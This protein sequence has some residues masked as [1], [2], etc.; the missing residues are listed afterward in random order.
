MLSLMPLNPTPGRALALILLLGCGSFVQAQVATAVPI[1]SWSLQNGR[2]ELRIGTEQERRYRIESSTNLVSW[3]TEMVTDPA[4]ETAAAVS[5]AAPLSDAWF[6]KVSTFE[7]EDLKAGLRTARERWEEQRLATYS[8]EFRW[9]CHCVFVDWVRVSVQ[10]GR[11]DEITSVATGTRL[12]EDQ[13]VGY[14]TVAG[15]FD[16]FDQQLAQRPV[17]IRAALDPV[18]GYPVSG[19]FDLSRLLADEEMGFEL[20][21]LMP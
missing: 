6:L 10:D 11:I 12:P 13:W 1:E 8:F 3:K 18:R 17:E 14:R 9:N 7:W 2:I 4:G 16:W 5:L 20:R 15:L 21:E 19:Y